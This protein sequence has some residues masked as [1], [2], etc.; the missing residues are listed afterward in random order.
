MT[1]AKAI[2]LAAKKPFIAINHLDG[3]AL[4]PRLS[5]SLEFPYL[6]LLISGGHSMFLAVEGPGKYK[7]LGQSIDCLLYTSPSPRD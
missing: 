3:H 5:H 2:S 7:L 6:L 1:T 4:T